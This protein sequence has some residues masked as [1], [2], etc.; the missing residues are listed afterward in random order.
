M[1]NMN[2]VKVETENKR[3]ARYLTLAGDLADGIAAGRYAVGSMLIFQAKPNYA[4]A[5]MS[6]GSPC[7]RR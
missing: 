1:R 5:T 7:A 4:S 3:R 6:A 2:V